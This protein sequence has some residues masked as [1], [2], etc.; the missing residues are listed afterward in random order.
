LQDDLG[1]L[2]S[3]L[4]ENSELED[5]P[6][7]QDFILVSHKRVPRKPNRL[8]LSGKASK[9]RKGKEN[10]VSKTRRK[11]RSKENLTSLHLSKRQKTQKRKI[12]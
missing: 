4:N 1:N 3:L 2:D 10:L 7:Q 9:A 12:K 6:K 11:G 5:G 8:S